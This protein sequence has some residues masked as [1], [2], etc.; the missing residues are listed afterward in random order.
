M[1]ITKILSPIA[2]LLLTFQLSGWG[3]KA[4]DIIA[5]IA[6]QN[7][8]PKAQSEVTR[9]LNGRTMVYY[10]M[11]MDNIRSDS[12]FDFTSTW[13]FAN[14]DSGYT[15]ATMPKAETGDVITAT[16]LSWQK[17]TSKTENDSIKKLYLKFMIHLIGE[18]H[19]PVHAGRKTDRGGND[20]PV[21]WFGEQTNL[22]SLWDSRFLERARSWS[23]T[24]WAANLT[25]N[26]T[27]ADIAQ[28]QRGTHRDWFDETVVIASYVYKHTPRNQNLRFSYIHGKKNILGREQTFLNI[29][30]QQLILGGYRLAYVLNTIFD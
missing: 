4:H 30:E 6:E 1:K 27:S 22:H 19:C 18:I 2:L 9:L 11:W 13:H 17:L 3:S 20:F 23:Y 8:T 25:S 28:M 15:Y 29:L 16:D 5:H 10:A 14:V 24:E 12:R 26:L 21:I 7:L